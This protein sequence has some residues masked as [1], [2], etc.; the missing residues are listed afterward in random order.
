MDKKTFYITTPIYYPSDKLHIGHAY[1]TV[2]ADT[3][4]RFKR[5]TGYDVMF[6]TGTDEHGQKI[7]RVAEACG[8]APQQY[9]DKIVEGIVKLWKLL[10]IS[11]DDFIRTT[12]PRH[13]KAVQKIFKKLYEKGDIYKSHYEGWYCTP[14]EAFWTEHQLADGKC[15]DCGREVELTR[16][17]AY[18]FRLSAY[19]NRLIKFIEET[20]FIQ[21]DSRKN[22]M[23]NNFLKPGLDDLCVSRTSFDWGIPVDFDEGHVVYVWVDALS[24]YITALGYASEDPSKYEKYW[25]ADVHLVGKE[26][27]RFHTII[28]PAMLM[29]LG[30][31][32]PKRVFGHGWLIL[33]GG[34]MSKSK[35]NVVD[36]V[37]LAERYGVDA[38]RY[39]LMR[40]MPFGADGVFSN[41]ALIG[42]INADL[43]NDLGNLVSRTVAMVDKYFSG[44][45]PKPSVEGEHDADLKELATS[46]PG[47]VEDYMEKLQFSNAL[48][49]VWKLIGS[50]NK[51]I[52]LTMPWVLAR[53][54]SKKDRLAT[55]IY[56]LADCIRI[57]S[58]LISPF[59]PNT[60]TLIWKQ[61]GMDHGQGTGWED[62][63]EFG[64]LPTGV[65]VRKGDI[66]FPRI[67][68]DGTKQRKNTKEKEES[69]VEEKF[70]SIDDFA[71]VD[72]RVATVLECEKVEKSKKLLK[73]R[74]DLGEET[75]QV[76]SGISE[77][78]SP[79]DLVGKQVVIVANLK[80]AKLMG[81]E[82]QGMILAASTP[83]DEELTVVTLLER[84][85]NGSKIT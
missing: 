33:E 31:P 10:D 13:V 14:C 61:L 84:I 12:E 5:L 54:E 42:R 30:E 68:Q 19:Q 71:K 6:L 82:S 74:L 2:A 45:I 72:L 24:N 55:V 77:F 4:A 40:E 76:V 43:A 85:A 62:T 59:M 11:N 1:C 50:T 66:I 25:P 26:I 49:E 79:E 52:D 46:T 17:E 21:P 15:P 37:V 36:P 18:F 35:G 48:T 67:E 78:Y 28:W 16:E 65:K 58:V 23:I 80:P 60:P 73:L 63:K 34:K 29:A 44:I 56:N 70:I 41:D 8:E 9:V 22:E 39:F 27:V 75:R 57:I 20:D 53:D 47:I 69:K 32:L 51:Y 7:Q 83:G 38:I 3:M 64:K 81:I